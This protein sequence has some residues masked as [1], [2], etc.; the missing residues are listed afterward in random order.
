[1]RSLMCSP[2]PSHGSDLP[3]GPAAAEELIAAVG[4]ETRHADTGRHIELIE[5]LTGPGIDAPQIAFVT[6]QSA[7]PKLPIDPRDSGNEAVG[8]DGA[9]NRAGLGIDL[10]NPAVPILADPQRAFGPGK[11]GV[12][13]AAWR[14]D[15]SKY[16]AGFGIDLADKILCDL[17]QVAAV[18][19]RS[20][21]GGDIDRPE[22][23]ACGGIE[24]VQLV[25]GSEPDLAAVPGDAV[26]SLSSGKGPVFAKDFGGGTIHASILF[27]RQR[28]GE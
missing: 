28:G 24:R 27:T 22:C 9:K 6:F 13:A 19:S 12:A 1:M 11:S 23:L 7:V 15:G 8:L 5:N 10:M 20:S 25:S 14:G 17:K 21:V 2:G 18:E 16:P 4:F 3:A 26:H